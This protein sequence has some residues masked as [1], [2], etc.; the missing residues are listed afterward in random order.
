M[1]NKKTEYYAICRL[2]GELCKAKRLGYEMHA[3]SASGTDWTLYLDKPTKTGPWILTE[4]TTGMSISPS[5][6]KKMKDVNIRVLTDIADM[7]DGNSHV[8][9]SQKTFKNTKTI[10]VWNYEK[11]MAII[12]DKPK[13]EVRE[14][15]KIED[16]PAPLPKGDRILD[17]VLIGHGSGFE[18]GKERIFQF[19]STVKNSKEREAFLK[20]EYGVGGFGNTGLSEFHDGKGISIRLGK[21]N[22]ETATY[23]TEK[24]YSWKEIAQRIGELVDAGVYMKEQ[25]PYEKRYLYM[26]G[27]IYS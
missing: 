18:S 21:Y 4:K 26:V 10:A 22:R 20:K 11:G 16:S 7:L 13:T 8:K 27:A 17:S 9:V 24:N 14:E 5:G 12:E 6:Y 2:G 19:F 1:A 23:L 25:T 3:I 15:S